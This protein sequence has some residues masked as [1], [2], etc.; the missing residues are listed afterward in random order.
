MVVASAMTD[1]DKV[2][3]LSCLFKMWCFQ[4]PLWLEIK[5]AFSA[6]FGKLVLFRKQ[7]QVCNLRTAHTLAQA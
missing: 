5:V 2:Y 6:N 7:L 1:K 3:H 4:T